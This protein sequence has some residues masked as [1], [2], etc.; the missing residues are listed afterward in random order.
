M[1]YIELDYALSDEAKAMGETA[2]KFAMQVMRPI[3]IELDKIADPADVIAKGSAFWK[4]IRQYR[5]LGFHKIGIPK[6]FGGMAGDIAPMAGTLISEMMGY[7]DGGLAICFGAGGMP[8]RFAAMS[9]EAELQQL[10]SVHPEMD[11]YL[12]LIK[13]MP[14]KSHF[15]VA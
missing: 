4:V 2:E 13:K 5:E 14:K 8:F 9:P 10:V 12:I 3:G 11:K 15:K 6:E 7:G 1:G